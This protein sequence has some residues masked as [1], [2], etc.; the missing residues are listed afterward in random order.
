MSGNAEGQP[1]EVLHIELPVRLHHRTVQH[2]DELLREFSYLDASHS[3]L[4]TRL[5]Q[6]R[7]DLRA[8]FSAFTS[9]PLAELQAASAAGAMSVD[10]RHVVP[11]AVGPAALQAMYML[12]A[13]DEFCRNGEHLLTLAAPKE[14]VHY[15]RWYFGEFARQCAGEPPTPWPVLQG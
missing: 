8:R 5:L 13:A 3:A 11:S 1:V 12:D 4:P 14:T 2:L 6:L 15:R 10:L 7:D 9:G